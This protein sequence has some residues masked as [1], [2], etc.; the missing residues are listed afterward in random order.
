MQVSDSTIKEQKAMLETHW[1][2]LLEKL[3]SLEHNL[4]TI[5]WKINYHEQMVI[6]S[7]TP[8]TLIVDKKHHLKETQK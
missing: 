7:P 8:Q 3:K 6:D 1:D 4:S 5:N 2:V